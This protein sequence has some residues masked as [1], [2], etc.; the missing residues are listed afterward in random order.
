MDN[1]ELVRVCMVIANIS[2]VGLVISATTG[3][4]SLILG[5]C[6]RL[7]GDPKG[8]Y[9]IMTVMK[10]SFFIALVFGINVVA[11]IALGQAG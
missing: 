9:P 2:V 8:S 11:W 7:T 6:L 3:I 5:L 1:S 4:G 10:W